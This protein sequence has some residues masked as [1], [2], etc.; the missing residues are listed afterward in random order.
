[1]MGRSAKHHTDAVQGIALANEP[2]MGI[3]PAGFLYGDI[4]QG[5]IADTSGNNFRPPGLLSMPSIRLI[6]REKGS[7]PPRTRT[8][9]LEI[10]S[11]SR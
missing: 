9:N 11:L 5:F 6:Y 2:C 8:W 10:K 3:F 7:E 4:G 1:M